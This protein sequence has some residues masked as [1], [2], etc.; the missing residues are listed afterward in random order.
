MSQLSD[1]TPERSDAASVEELFGEPIHVYTRRQAIEDGILKPVARTFTVDGEPITICF[2]AN[3]FTDFTDEERRV[4]L[5]SDGLIALAQHD[6]EDDAYRRL[7][8]LRAETIWVIWDGDG[9]TFLYP[10][11][12]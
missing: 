11:D 1:P 7:R 5:I 9:I 10:S 3:L 8:V 2:T 4:A 12:Y 6:E